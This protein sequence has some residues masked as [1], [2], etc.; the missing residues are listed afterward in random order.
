MTRRTASIKASNAGSK[1]KSSPKPKSKPK[2]KEP[3]ASWVDLT[4]DHLDRWAGSRSVER[5]RSYERGGRVSGLSITADGSLLAWV[6]GTY[7]YATTVSLAGTGAKPLLESSC[8]CPVGFACKHAVAVVASYLDAVASGEDVPVADEDDDRWAELESGGYTGDEWDAY[9]ADDDPWEEDDPDDEPAPPRRRGRKA[10]GVGAKGKGEGGSAWDAKIERHIRS[11]SEEELADLVLALTKRFP[12][13]YRELKDRV[14]LQDGDADLLVAETRR[15]IRR[16]TAQEA[17]VNAWTGE[18]SLPDYEPIRRRLARLLELGCADEVVSLGRLLLAEGLRQ[19]GE[20]HDEGET[21][22]ALSKCFP[23]VFRAVTRSS[24]SGPDRLLMAIDAVLEDDYGVLDEAVGLVLDGPS[25]AEDWS[26]AADRLLER[27]EDQDEPGGDP[28]EPGHFHRSYG[29]DRIT[30]W[31]ATALEHSGRPDELEKI[32]EAEARR[33]LS[34]ERLVDFHLKR[35]RLDDAERW[36][37]EGISQTIDRLPGIATHLADR[38]LEVARARKKWDVVASHAAVSFFE[39]PR[40][41]GFDELIKAARKAKAE[42]AVREH[43]LRF[44]ETGVLPVRPPAPPPRPSRPRSKS[45]ARST[46]SSSAGP[47]PTPEAPKAPVV[48]PGWPLPT[49]DYLVPFLSQALRFDP[50][51]RPHLD[52]L[53]QMAIAAK[54]PEAVLRWY[55]RMKAEPSR[56]PYSYDHA[57]AYADRVAGAVAD[58]HP[59]RAIAIY[60]DALDAQLPHA[61]PSA[62]EAA[63]GYLRKLRPLYMAVGRPEEWE[64]LLSSIR[65]SYRNRPR[66]MEQLDRLDGRPIVQSPRGRS[67]SGPNGRR[68]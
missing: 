56:S 50:E 12:E 49:P 61:R 24:L 39:R 22:L 45:R 53:L 27:L 59:D 6:D 15:E 46:G 29:R 25:S 57:R 65:E 2:P 64:V 1:P 7:R 60:R 18:G 34:Y 20:S 37:R 33:T 9:G 40:P 31:I 35:R 11:K 14:A 42:P 17:W 48:D 44:L 52:V 8:T 51:P 41:S 13:L 30:D 63:A 66:F 38:L 19:V 68:R 36:A 67:R 32:Y 47:A 16:V 4:W 26:M 21:S 54:D 58:S 5:G 55:D 10:R 23:V 3:A 62:Y 28:S 43:A